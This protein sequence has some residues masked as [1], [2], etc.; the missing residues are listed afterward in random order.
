MAKI[1]LVFTYA[2]VITSFF[3]YAKMSSPSIPQS[4]IPQSSIPQ[5]S[6]LAK[7]LQTFKPNHTCRKTLFLIDT[8]QEVYYD[9][10]L[11]DTIY[12]G[13][14]EICIIYEHLDVKDYYPEVEIEIEREIESE[15]Q[16]NKSHVKEIYFVKYDQYRKDFIR[17]KYRKRVKGACYYYNDEGNIQDMSSDSFKNSSSF[18][19]Y[20]YYTTHD[21]VEIN[22]ELRPF[23]SSYC[24][25]IQNFENPEGRQKTLELLKLC[26]N[27]L[28]Y[29]R[30]ENEYEKDDGTFNIEVLK[31]LPNLKTISILY[32]ASGGR[33]ETQEE[34]KELIRCKPNHFKF[35]ENTGNVKC[36][37]INYSGY[38][39]FQNI[40]GY[41]LK[42]LSKNPHLEKLYLSDFNYVSSLEIEMLVN[43]LPNLKDFYFSGECMNENL[44]EIILRKL[45]KLETFSIRSEKVSE[46]FIEEMRTEYPH[47]KI[48]CY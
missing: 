15:E 3:T 17:E 44:V 8:D 23:S 2:N 32:Y 40:D 46:E 35:L 14:I 6:Q 47:V 33:Y 1:D 29:I 18:R 43:S 38:L 31:C 13:D 20:K 7:H 21:V 9:H 5:C 25:I 24:F 45:Q 28:E 4:S 12:F 36:V 10:L 37:D 26:G 22:P 19:S 34:Y 16:Y 11:R 41:I 39:Q 42:A 30:F 48:D 27:D